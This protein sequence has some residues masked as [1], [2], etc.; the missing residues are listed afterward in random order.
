MGSVPSRALRKKSNKMELTLGDLVTAFYDEAQRVAR[1]PDEA[2]LLAKA[3][4]TDCLR[5]YHA[6]SH[7][8]DR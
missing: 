1:D 5:R 8:R 7:R 6:R 4:V 2:D 3:S